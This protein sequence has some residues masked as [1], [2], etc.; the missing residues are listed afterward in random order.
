M[1]RRSNRDRFIQARRGLQR[2]L[3][4]IA[5]TWC[6]TSNPEV[7]NFIPKHHVIPNLLVKDLLVDQ[8]NPFAYSRTRKAKKIPL[9][10]RRE[11]RSG[12][13][14]TAC[15]A[16][17]KIL[18]APGLNNNFYWQVMD[19][20][21]QN[22][23]A[24]G[25]EDVVFLY[26]PDSGITEEL[27]R[28]NIRRDDG[29]RVSLIE[30][31]DYEETESN[32]II[33]PRN[34][35][36]QQ[37]NK[38][39]ENCI[40]TPKTGKVFRYLKG[41]DTKSTRE[42]FPKVFERRTSADQLFARFG[43]KSNHSR[44]SFRNRSLPNLRNKNSKFDIFKKLNAKNISQNV[45]FSERK[46]RILRDSFQ[47]PQ[48]KTN[49]SLFEGNLTKQENK[50]KINLKNQKRGKPVSFRDS[51]DPINMLSNL[52]FD[53][54]I[55][56][57]IESFG[58]PD[59]KK[60]NNPFLAARIRISPDLKN[61]KRK[62]RFE[63]SQEEKNRFSILNI[64]K[65][66]F[67]EERSK[68]EV[69][70]QREEDPNSQIILNLSTQKS[71]SL[72]T[73]EEVP[74]QSQLSL[75]F[76]LELG[77]A[78]DS[79]NSIFSSEASSISSQSSGCKTVFSDDWGEQN[80]VEANPFKNQNN[81][82]RRLFGDN[83]EIERNSLLT[84][85]SNQTQSNHQNNSKRGFITNRRGTIESKSLSQ[86][87]KNISHSID[88]QGKLDFNFPNL[89]HA[90]NT[91]KNER[92]NRKKSVRVPSLD[93]SIGSLNQNSFQHMSGGTSMLES[94]ELIAPSEDSFDAGRVALRRS[95][96]SNQSGNM[97]IL[98]PN[99]RQSVLALA[100]NRAIGRESGLLTVNDALSLDDTVP[101]QIKSLKFNLT[102][103][104]LA[105]CDDT[106]M[107][108]IFEME[109]KRSLYS[110]RFE[111]GVECVR[112]CEESILALGTLSGNV[113]I[114]D[115]SSGFRS[116]LLS[117]KMHDS[118]IVSLDFSKNGAFLASTCR[119]NNLRALDLGRLKH[120]F[121][122]SRGSFLFNL[123]EAS[124]V[125]RRDVIHLAT[126]SSAIKALAWHPTRPQ[127]L[128]VG[129][130]IDDRRIRVFDAAARKLVHISK[131]LSQITGLLFASNGGALV[132]AHGEP[133]N[134]V[135][136]WS[137]KGVRLVL[138]TKLEGFANRPL[139]IS[140]GPNGKQLMTAEADQTL[141][142]WRVFKGEQKKDKKSDLLDETLKKIGYRATR[143]R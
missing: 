134:C 48:K 39:S 55:P 71:I 119:K 92:M 31:R 57:E 70:K 54:L 22:V 135:R 5:K 34:I 108:Q 19:W 87:Q 83:N 117:V 104:L 75:N 64:K 40:N 79:E 52:K 66:L 23:L 81:V 6:P 96:S 127:T 61:K 13:I 51:L 18:D 33:S 90:N 88:N 82:N 47:T 60:V 3:E 44:F 80:Q 123:N 62:S 91:N 32:Q 11:S 38:L 65:K 120:A 69:N 103:K 67:E 126:T 26:Y 36:N 111:T 73:N 63:T 37:F 107:V 2:E 140:L 45:H 124:S 12:V 141:R 142:M 101:S 72:F 53:S 130:G 128:F 27:E 121:F 132:S 17:I 41:A 143:F 137:V 102:G 97:I 25:I 85:N 106:R 21:K 46:T 77:E 110:R 43:L 84:E 122:S 131:P 138:K 89:K 29:G 14:S 125:S 94:L 1:K 30:R 56:K 7:S 118:P 76:E 109:T 42:G 20:S 133:D 139:A 100:L 136:V 10:E 78:T 112:F 49:L 8:L 16:P 4:D 98:N 35:Q 28:G 68:L 74:D 9:T 99:R 59:T 24:V 114:Y 93:L 129:G 116:P 95:R 58:V 113:S 15:E 105:V 50:N 86:I 115:I